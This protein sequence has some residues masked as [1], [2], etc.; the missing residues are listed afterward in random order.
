MRID[1]LC[2]EVFQTAG[3]YKF[4]FRSKGLSYVL[5]LQRAKRD[6][7]IGDTLKIDLPEKGNK[8]GELV[9]PVP[10]ETS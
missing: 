9:E 5:F 3:T 6:F 8:D 7:K 1:L 10:P 2:T 4:T